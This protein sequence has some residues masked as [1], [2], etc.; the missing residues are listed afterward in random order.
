MSKHDRPIL[1]FAIPAMGALAID[2]LVSLV[3]TAFVGRLG[4]VPLGAL[5]VNSGVFGLA[6][7]VFN[8]LAYGTTPLVAEAAARG[9]RARA[10]R[11]VVAGLLLAVGLG[12]VAIGVLE[13]LAVPIATLMGAD[14]TLLGPT[15][16]YMRIRA[17]AAP[18]VLLVTAGHGA[19]RG[20]QDTRTP[21]RV[22]VLLNL[23]NAVL[24]P[25]LIFGA[26]M[27]LAGAAWATVAAQWAGAGAFLWLLLGPR[28]RELGIVARWPG[29]A[30]LRT[31]LS[32]GSVLSVRTFALVATMTVATAIA[33]R[34]GPQVVAAHQVARE[35]WMFLA[36][37]VDAFA[38][39]GQA[40]VADHLGAD[41]PGVAREV[42][43]RLLLWG[44]GVGAI[45]VGLVLAAWPLFP[46]FFDLQPGVMGELSPV[47]PIVAA[48]QPLNAL[49]FV[50]DGVFM[51]ARR[52]G[53]LAGSMVVA[54]GCTGAVLWWSWSTRAGLEGVWW[55]LVVL[56]A[57]RGLTQAV[58][59]WGPWAIL[60]RSGGQGLE[61]G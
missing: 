27:G 14:E 55:A 40:L 8:F 34:F 52:F 17:L 46:W 42:A 10:G 23:V 6:F 4:T 59:W 44:L 7:V 22:T 9:D 48:M 37:V 53:W 61:E 49:V 41:R 50:W 25:L 32:V 18:A 35:A 38:L 47:M 24:D 58:R 43:D 30:D 33:T 3:D 16:T 13:S 57:V 45:S 19:F 11:L 29:L 20:Y 54:A 12:A 5:G 2:P 56:I 36:L 15:V 31:L 28:G 26:G 39:A 21:L 51:G 60:P 1:R